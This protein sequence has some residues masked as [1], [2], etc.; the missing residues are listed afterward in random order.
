MEETER[1]VVGNDSKRN[2]TKTTRRRRKKDKTK[3]IR[4]RRKKDKTKLDGGGRKTKLNELEDKLLKSV[5]DLRSN[6]FHVL[7]KL[8]M[9]KAFLLKDSDKHCL[10]EEFTA[11]RGWL[12]K[13]MK[14]NGLS[15]RRKTTQAQ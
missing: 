2:W 10:V 15:L 4:R 8:I 13:C 11:S 12:E 6:G 14:R 5:L 3:R 9:R 7:R 1:E